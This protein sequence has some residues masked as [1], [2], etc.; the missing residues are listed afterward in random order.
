MSG[1]GHQPMG[2]TGDREKGEFCEVEGRAGL[3][4][5]GGTARNLCPGRLREERDRSDGAESHLY[6]WL[7]TA[8]AQS[9]TSS[10]VS[11]PRVLHLVSLAGSCSQSRPLLHTP[12]TRS[13]TQLACLNISYIH[14]NLTTCLPSSNPRPSTLPLH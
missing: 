5:V 3:L 8:R 4:G 7:S 14:N 9:H 12:P 13:Q 2:Q 11:P 10:G 6:S 1:G